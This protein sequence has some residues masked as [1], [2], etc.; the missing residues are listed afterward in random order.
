MR[1]LYCGKE[2]A[3]LKRLT[4][5]GE[6]CSDV[7]KQSYQEEYNRLALSRLLQAQTKAED[8]KT[9][10][11]A[12]PQPAAAPAPAAKPAK[13]R[14]AP[15]AQAIEPAQFES[16]SPARHDPHP[17]DTSTH[18][19][20]PQDTRP[21]ETSEE[22]APAGLAGFLADRPA[23]R[24]GAEAVLQGEDPLCEPARPAL[25]EW[26]RPDSGAAEWK[27]G[28]GADLAAATLFSLGV[29]PQANGSAHLQIESGIAPK[30]FSNPPLS[31][32][33]R[34]QVSEASMRIADSAGHR[35]TGSDAR[36]G[37]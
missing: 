6:F 11:A 16:G 37:A 33:L 25:P 34:Q 17:R 21:D 8:H 2:L 26:Q 4:G 31:M 19:A 30:E 20:R 18:D 27:G 12:A 3:L 13:A 15:A 23:P 9:A 24:A 32:D 28:P 22:M 10:K 5:G 36:N 35:R 1:C 14:Q 7:H 29:R